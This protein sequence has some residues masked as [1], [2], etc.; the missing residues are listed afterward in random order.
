MIL[1]GWC[2]CTHSQSNQKNKRDQI[3]RRGHIQVSAHTYLLSVFEIKR[4]LGLCSG[5]LFARHEGCSV[6]CI[7]SPARQVEDDDCSKQSSLS[8]C[9][10]T[11]VFFWGGGARVVLGPSSTVSKTSSSVQ[12]ERGRR[13]IKKITKKSDDAGRLLVPGGVPGME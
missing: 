6:C 13:Q 3:H 11:V 7:L 2:G 10:Q 5:I 12:R 9:R 4:V 1:Q 8:L